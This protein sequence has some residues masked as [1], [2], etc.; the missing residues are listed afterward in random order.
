M[1][2]GSLA[3]GA[4]LPSSSSTSSPATTCSP[5]GA[6]TATCTA[7]GP[8]RLQAGDEIIAAGPDGGRQHL[9]ERCGWRLRHDEETGES[10]L[11]PPSGSDANG[12][13]GA[14]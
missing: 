9:A 13:P 8:V 14:P 7:P 5:C 3:D 4:A 1:A 2:G 10:E 6:T 11:L 12:A